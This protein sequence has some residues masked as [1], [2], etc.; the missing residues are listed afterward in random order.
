MLNE[1]NLIFVK[2]LNQKNIKLIKRRK[3]GLKDMLGLKACTE[4]LSIKL[5]HLYYPRRMKR[6]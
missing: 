2:Y 3:K 4:I 5:I 1:D 6:K